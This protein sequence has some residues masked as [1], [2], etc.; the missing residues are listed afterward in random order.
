MI[1]SHRSYHITS[2]CWMWKISLQLT[3]ISK[4]FEWFGP[5]LVRQGFG[6]ESPFSASI[7]R[8]KMKLETNGAPIQTSEVIFGKAPPNRGRNN[9]FCRKFSLQMVWFESGKLCCTVWRK[10]ILTHEPLISVRL[11]RNQH[12][13]KKNQIGI[14]HLLCSYFTYI[15]TAIAKKNHMR[16]YLLHVLARCN[17][18]YRLLNSWQKPKPLHSFTFA[19]RVHAI[20]IKMKNIYRNNF[21]PQN[22]QRQ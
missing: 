15:K 16:N 8:Q 5:N 7:L 14:A 9:F 3:V 2:L 6:P 11:F 19:I 13:K 4:K 20:K 12:L 21:M 17:L 18:N 22:N 10:K 1:G